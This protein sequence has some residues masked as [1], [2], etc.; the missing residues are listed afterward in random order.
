MKD[1]RETRG[2][3]PLLSEANEKLL[4]ERIRGLD[5]SNVPAPWK[6]ISDYAH[7]MWRAQEGLPSK[8]KD[9]YSSNNRFTYNWYVRFSERHNLRI[10]KLSTS[11]NDG[12]RRT[13]E[14]ARRDV[15]RHRE[16]SRDDSRVD[17]DSLAAYGIDVNELDVSGLDVSPEHIERVAESLRVLDKV[18]AHGVESKH[19]ELVS[20]EEA[21][22]ALTVTVKLL[23]AMYRRRGYDLPR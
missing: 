17:R 21:D 14:E 13:E 23:R 12:E 22:A 4:A 7:S 5:E 16:T 8:D 1:L 20:D 11:E 10:T 19:N 2:R 6:K 18:L 15:A 9:D 3:K